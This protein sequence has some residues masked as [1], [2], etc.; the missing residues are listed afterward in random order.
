MT[1]TPRNPKEDNHDETPSPGSTKDH[2]SEKVP[3]TQAPT[4]SPDKLEEP[5]FKKGDRS[6][7]DPNPY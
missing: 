6:M 1:E 4:F 7:G 3:T 5:L 2:L